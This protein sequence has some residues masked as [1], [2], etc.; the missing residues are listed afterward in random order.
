ML[1]CLYV[2][3]CN[4]GIIIDMLELDYSRNPVKSVRVE[5]SQDK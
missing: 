3:V 2:A 4:T 5:T 1:T